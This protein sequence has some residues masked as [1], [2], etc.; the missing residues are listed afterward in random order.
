M[1]FAR[2]ARSAILRRSVPARRDDDKRMPEALALIELTSI[3]RGA[4]L[5]DDVSKKAPVAIHTA[6]P[7]SSGKYLLIF[8]GE[9]G[10]VEES[11]R[12]ALAVG[13][14]AVANKL[15]L[16]QVH[17]DVVRSMEQ[18]LE[19]GAVDVDAL[20]IVETTSMATAVGAADAAAKAAEVRLVELR[21]GFGIGGR[22]YFTL[23]G[24]HADVEAA[25]AAARA[26]GERDAT[27]VDVEIIP[28]PHADV[29]DNWT[30]AGWAAQSL[31]RAR[32][33]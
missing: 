3:G 30:G 9:V 19:A 8:V 29:V 2:G 7:V 28:R 23:T 16:P 33:S 4:R 25:V 6:T 24:S 14:T 17:P 27:L 20:A 13:S 1:I 15:L 18:R 12:E 10:P 22:G 31:P 21:L 26:V 32:R 5:L 11:F